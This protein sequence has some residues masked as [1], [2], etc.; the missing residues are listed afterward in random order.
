MEISVFANTVLIAEN[1]VNSMAYEISIN[2]IQADLEK[3]IYIF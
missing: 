1:K 2:F 3:I